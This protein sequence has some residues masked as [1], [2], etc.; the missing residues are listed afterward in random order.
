MRYACTEALHF[1]TRKRLIQGRVPAPDDAV[2][3]DDVLSGCFIKKK[4]KR[5]TPA[6]TGEPKTEQ[7]RRCTY[8]VTLRRVRVTTVA[9]EKQ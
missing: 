6:T 5:V 8:N 1:S 9:V 3:H 4:K 2:R 7:D